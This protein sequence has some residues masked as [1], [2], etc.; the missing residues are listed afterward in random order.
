MPVEYVCEHCGRRL[1]VTVRFVGRRIA[2][3]HCRRP[4]TLPSSLANEL[5]AEE[6][7]R[8]VPTTAGTAAGS[9]TVVRPASQP[10]VSSVER[11]A[12]AEAQGPDSVPPGDR[13]PRSSPPADPSERAA[14][15]VS[16]PVLPA[17]RNPPPA[18]VPAPPPFD[19]SLIPEPVAVSQPS[20]QTLGSS[21]ASAMPA[22]AMPVPAWGM[23]AGTPTSP[24]AMPIQVQPPQGVFVPS[25][26]IVMQ[27][28]LL[29]VM[30]VAGIGVGWF[31]A[32]RDRMLRAPQP[33]FLT[34]TVRVALA[35]GS[36]QVDEG[37]IVLL[38]PETE[39]PERSGRLS[40]SQL[41]QSSGSQEGGSTV[42]LVRTWGGDLCRVETGGFYYLRAKDAG[43]YYVLFLSSHSRSEAKDLDR[44]VL[45]ELGRYVDRPHDLLGA[46]RFAWH[47]IQLSAD[48]RLDVTLTE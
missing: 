46:R 6:A 18:A 25:S 22:S 16:Q 45:A 17:E 2:C 24:P 48:R 29:A 23:S 31:V 32:E 36:Q 28:L 47:K 26:V 38:L 41:L 37:A 10:P 40:V 13:P 1:Q 35:D 21:T 27:G 34:G 44:Q 33:S 9:K 30:A 3:P 5:S 14:T 42:E 12:A 20:V 19:P 39:R 8:E 7:K 43:T 15:A 11:H 4:I